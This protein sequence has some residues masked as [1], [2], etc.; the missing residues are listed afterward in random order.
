MKGVA[1]RYPAFDPALAR[2]LDL[3]QR[4]NRC[5]TEH[6]RAEPLAWESEDLLALTAFVAHQSRGL[7]IAVPSDARVA[8]VSR[9]GQRAVPPARRPA[10]PVLQPVPRRQLGQAARRQRDSARTPDRLPGLSPRMAEPRLAA[11]AS[12]QLHDRGA[13]R[14]LRLRRPRSRRPRTL[15]DG[16][17]PRA[18]RSTPRRCA[19]RGGRVSSFRNADHKQESADRGR[20]SDYVRARRARLPPPGSVSPA[21]AFRSGRSISRRSASRP[22][23]RRDRTVPT[24]TLE[25]LR[26]GFVGHSFKAD[27][28][29]DFTLL[30]G[31]R[32][33]ARSSSRSWRDAVGSVVATSEDDICS[34]S[35][36]APSRIARRTMLTYW[37][38]MIVKSQARMSVPV[39]QR[40]DLGD[41]A[42]QGLLHEI[43]RPVGTPGKRPGIASKPW[44]LSLDE[45]IKFGHFVLPFCRPGSP[46]LMART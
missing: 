12:A 30:R 16:A 36:V 17:G 15:S 46:R 9:P 18:C 38:C 6:Q 19:R 34:M 23:D 13:R 44:N 8:P 2:P 25:D 22:R 20:E 14:A 41:R 29:D 45:A 43:V 40:W 28:Q 10:E 26:R 24:G 4:I 7:P 27:E 32:A 33:S 21:T 1:A 31:R 39:C 42:Q 37:L 11:A 35:T 5:R 3:E